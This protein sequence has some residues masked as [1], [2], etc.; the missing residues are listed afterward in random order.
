MFWPSIANAASNFMPPQASE[1][2]TRV[3]SLYAFLLWASF[4]S[5]VLVIGG[6]LYFTVKYKRKSDNDKTAYISHNTYL[7]FLWSFI[8]F[9]IFMFV[10]AW[11]FYIFK[12]MRSMPKDALEILVEGQ[13]W[14]WTFYYKNG[15]ISA[16]ELVVPVNTPVKLVM[17][18]KDVLHSFFIPAMRNK[19][20]LVP[21]RYT[22]LWFNADKK[23]D[24]QVFC[25][26]YC[27]DQHSGMLAKLKVINREDFDQWLQNDPYKG[28]TMIEVGHKVYEAR[29]IACHSLTVENSAAKGAAQI[30]PGWK[31][32][33]GDQRTFSDGTTGKADENYLRES[34]LNPNAKTVAGYS[35]VMPTFAGQLSEQ[36]IMSVIEMIKS[37]K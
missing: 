13:K 5:C 8:P 23:G 19:Q 36:E 22:T 7:E 24:F 6:F 28:L 25:A 11:G 18:S 2:A 20:D 26:E 3:D 33:Y 15:K 14:N 21:G 12:D 1:I 31:G 10:F 35:P 37:D 29:C 30:A 4:I 32:L 17:T 34:I 16:S 9:V 27:G